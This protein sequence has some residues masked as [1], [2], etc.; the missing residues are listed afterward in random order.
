VSWLQLAAAPLYL[1]IISQ[2]AKQMKLGESSFA[3]TYLYESASHVEAQ[4]SLSMTHGYGN[5]NFDSHG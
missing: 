3:F 4:L 2:R 1:E 5:A